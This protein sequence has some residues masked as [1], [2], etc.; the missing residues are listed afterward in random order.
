MNGGPY[1]PV[2]VTTDAQGNV[3]AD[4]LDASKNCIAGYWAKG[5]GKFIP[6]GIDC[7]DSDP[8]GNVPGWIVF[9]SIGNLL[10]G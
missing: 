3:W 10:L 5:G 8:N 1:S 9:D 6:A 2:D 4:G 7:N